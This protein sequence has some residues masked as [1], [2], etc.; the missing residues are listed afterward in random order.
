MPRLA[1]VTR[2]TFSSR[3][4]MRCP[5]VDGD[6]ET[7]A[8]LAVER[9]GQ[10]PLPPGVLH[11][12]DLAGADLPRLAVAGRDLHAGVEVDDVLAAWGGVPAEVGVWLDL[13]GDEAGGPP[14]R[15]P[16]RPHIRRAH[17]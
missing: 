10:M 6:E 12:Q 7:V 3:R 11:Q 5:S 8:H 14:R 4:A 15:G 2:T 9:L 13:A 1:P 17:R 16:S